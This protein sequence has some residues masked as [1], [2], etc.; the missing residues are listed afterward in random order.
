MILKTDSTVIDRPWD[1]LISGTL[2]AV[3]MCF[4]SQVYMHHTYMYTYNVA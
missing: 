4:T 2:A 1:Y 3:T